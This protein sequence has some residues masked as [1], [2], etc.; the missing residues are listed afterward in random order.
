MMHPHLEYLKNLISNSFQCEFSNLQIEKESAEYGA[1]N[2]ILNIESNKS[3]SIEFRVAKITPK[4]NWS[5][6]NIME[7]N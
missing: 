7:K 2:F 4:K 5:I 3:I 1:C 6:C